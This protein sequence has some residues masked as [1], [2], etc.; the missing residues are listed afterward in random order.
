MNAL[1]SF[2]RPSNFPYREVFYF[3][4]EVALMLGTY[5]DSPDKS[6]GIRWMI[7]ESDLGF[8]SNRGNPMWMVA[9]DKL[10]LYMLEGILENIEQEHP[11]IMNWNEFMEALQCLRSKN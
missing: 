3:D 4:S 10:A 9:P 7:S 5:K 6:V 2:P 8:P 1:P 11:S